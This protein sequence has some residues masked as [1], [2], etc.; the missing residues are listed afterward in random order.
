MLKTIRTRSAAAA[1]SAV[2]ILSSCFSIAAFADDVPPE[3]TAR[4]SNWQPVG[5]SGGDV[6]SVTIDPRDKNKLFAS[7]ASSLQCNLKR[8]IGRRCLYERFEL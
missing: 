8:W 6:R 5:P 4:Y 7:T 2:A 3:P 1:L